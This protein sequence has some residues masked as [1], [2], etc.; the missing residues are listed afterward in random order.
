[1]SATATC[2]ATATAPVAAAGADGRSS[3]VPLACF[4]NGRPTAPPRNNKM[5]S[6]L[7]DVF[8]PSEALEA[9]ISKQPKMSQARWGPALAQLGGALALLAFSVLLLAV[10]PWFF[11]PV[12]WMIAGASLSLLFII[13]H[14][15]AHGN[16]APSPLVNS[17]VGE[18]AFLLLLQPFESFKRDHA[19]A[20]APR[21]TAAVAPAG[22]NPSKAKKAAAPTNDAGQSITIEAPCAA[23]TEPLPSW[24]LAF[25]N[26][27][28]ANYMPSSVS[29]GKAPRLYASIALSAVVSVALLALLLSLPGYGGPLAVLR[30]WALPLLAY[31][32]TYA[33]VCRLFTFNVRAFLPADHSA[34]FSIASYNYALLTRCL[35]ASAEYGAL[36]SN[37]SLVSLVRG[38]YP[39]INWINLFILSFVPFISLVGLFTTPL[40][41]KTL[42]W[43]LFYYFITGIGITAGYHRLFA[44][45]SYEANWVTRVALIF[46]GSGALQGSIKWWCGGHRIHHRYTD[47]EKD[48]YNSQGGFWYAHIGWM[49]LKPDPKHYVKADIK[50]LDADPLIRFQH[51]WYLFVGP[52]CAFI[53]PTLVAGLGWGD[54]MGGYFYA[55]AARL[56][57]VHHSTFCVNSVAHYFGE[58][59]FDDDRS[60]RDHVITALLTFGEGYH[61]FH[62]EFPNDYRNGIQW[63]HYDPTKW[64][65]AALSKV[66]GTFNLKVFPK[67][68]IRRGVLY[69][70]EKKLAEL[71]ASVV[72]PKGAKELPAWDME[73]VTKLCKEEGRQLI[74]VGEFVHDVSVFASC[75]P[76]GVALLKAYVGRDA[77]KVF[78]GQT[79]PV[80]YQHS[81][82][83]E[84]LLSNMRVASLLCRGPEAGQDRESLDAGVELA[85]Q[86]K[87]VVA[88]KEL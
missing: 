38:W 23:N 70:R 62:H 69:M 11:L 21:K 4:G 72:P 57:F 71:R 76:G 42:Y 3:R 86:T 9:F 12:A 75:H 73:Q 18:L 50:D 40:Q 13:G 6:K 48:P 36:V 54:W 88:K 77:T 41:Q 68:E 80:V 65:I 24:L 2:V 14:D 15:C 84:N 10:S 59:T 32:S 30:F 60:P 61:N 25:F 20:D 83:A 85:L 27:I 35:E 45:K 39:R 34:S 19:C 51:K 87:T 78:R 67:N 44:H 28:S 5:P 63:Y 31:V 43:S 1:M 56:F 17:L 47:T 7:P 66:G 74:V 22:A 33:G 46:A 64:I 79:N 53:F 82:A 37:S 52:F 8:V 26:H 55:G 58:H 49:L 81:H 16:W 29:A